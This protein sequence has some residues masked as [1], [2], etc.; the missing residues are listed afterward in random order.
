MPRIPSE[1]EVLEYFDRFSNWGRWGPNDE[2]G[3][4]NLITPRKRLDALG[5]PRAGVSV[6]CAWPIVKEPPVVDVS[7]PPQHFMLRSGETPGEIAGLDFVG[8]VFH[9]FTITHVDALSHQFWQGKMYNGRSTTLVST[10]LGAQECSVEVLKDGIVT[11]GVLL[12]IAG[13]KG[14]PYL[15][16]GEGIFP[17]DLEQ[18]ERTQ[19]VKVGEG[20]ALLVR[21]GW[22]TRRNRSGP[23]PNPPARPGLHAA[24]VPWLYERGVAVIGADAAHDVTPSGYPKVSLPVHM[25][26]MT[27]MGLC[28]IDSCQLDDLL[29]ECKQ[30]GR[31]EFLFVVAP[32]R[33]RYATGSPVTPIA[34]L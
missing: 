34:I 16:A 18:A 22:L 4:L 29:A 26:G 32:W 6:G 20:D 28:L 1:A 12:D 7:H 33:F 10:A 27:M 24:T 30:R 25:V 17:E 21:T 14:R 9:G 2:L 13:L 5:I 8:L 19:S 31:W 11:R 23:H 15:E 3:T